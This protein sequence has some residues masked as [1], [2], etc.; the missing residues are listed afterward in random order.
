MRFAEPDLLWLLLLLP[1]LGLLTWL[2]ARA[3]RR[4]LE[5][6]AG[7]REHASRFTGAVS[8][9]R[10]AVKALLV[11]AALGAGL[12]AAARPQ[13]GTRLE[14]INRRGVDVVFV[15]DTS[16]SMAAE[17]VPPNRLGQARHVA[18]SLLRRLGGDRIAIVTFAGKGTLACPLTLDHE[19]ALLFL[20]SLDVDLVPVP[21]SSIA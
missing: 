13:W 6:F 12:V 18:S 19:A 17:D 14:P 20:D 10:R 9:N 8:Q 3:R 4:T 16:L 5:R 1:I 15:I 2:V 21:G 11:L 7:G